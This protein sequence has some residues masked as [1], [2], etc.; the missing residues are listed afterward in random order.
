[1]MSDTDPQL[2]DE[3]RAVTRELLGDLAAD[4]PGDPSTGVL[5]WQR[6]AGSGWLGLEIPESL[7]G[8]AATFAEVGVVLE[9]LGR[10]AACTP[11]LGSV[12][13]AAGALAL[14]EPSTARDGLLRGIAG[15]SRVSLA[16][17]AGDD[18][19]IP[20]RLE[21]DGAELRLCGH[22]DFVVDADGADKLLVIAVD[23]A[24]V[25]VVV[26]L[27]S[28]AEFVGPQ[29]VLDE[30]RALGVIHVDGVS[31][32]RGSVW[33][34]VADPTGSCDRLRLR[35]AV[36]VACDSLGIAE[37]MLERTV[38]YATV[39]RQFG[40]EI[41]SFQ[42]VKHACADM[43]VS[44]TLGRQLLDAAVD[45]VATADPSADVAVAMAKSQICAAAVDV[46]GAAVQLH[47]GIGYTWESGLHRYLKRA[48]LNRSLFGNPIAYRRRLAQRLA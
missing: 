7:D 31:V 44:V 17:P 35:A 25:P 43:L 6:L 36:A 4:E 47:G 42:A 41:G 46:L 29:P 16:L 20:F 28:P 15:G 13:L 32:P 48:L 12:V 14:V 22:L 45:A 30:T 5:A 23:P 21:G 34:F 2:R 18:P 9:E 27:D 19:H 39:R 24:G 11:Y 38:A 33:H 1:M 37:L 8:A 3:I 10:A 40:R 26:D